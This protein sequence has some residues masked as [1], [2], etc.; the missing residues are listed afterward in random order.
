MAVDLHVVNGVPCSH[1]AGNS[2]TGGVHVDLKILLFLGFLLLLFFGDHGN[3]DNLVSQLG[4]SLRLLELLRELDGQFTGERTEV[5]FGQADNKECTGNNVVDVTVFVTQSAVQRQT[6]EL[7]FLVADQGNRIVVGIDCLNI[8]ANHALQ[9]FQTGIDL[10]NARFLSRLNNHDNDFPVVFQLFAASGETVFVGNVIKT[11]VKHPRPTVSGIAYIAIIGESAAFIH[12]HIA[13]KT[14]KVNVVCE[15]THCFCVVDT[16]FF[17]VVASQILFVRD[18][19]KKVI[20]VQ[21]VGQVDEIV[22]VADFIAASLHNSNKLFLIPFIH[23]INARGKV[24]ELIK[25]LILTE[26]LLNPIDGTLVVGDKPFLVHMAELIL[27]PNPDSFKDLLH[28]FLGC[29]ELYPFTDQLTLVVLA[30]V[31]DKRLETVIHNRH[32]HPPFSHSSCCP[33]RYRARRTQ[34]QTLLRAS[35]RF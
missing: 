17:D 6:F 32:R 8:A 33:A 29:R 9:G 28:L 21:I 34:R 23:L 5:V 12:C 26:Q 35:G 7:A 2:Q 24:V 18:I 16:G 25:A 15:I 13:S 27:R 20:A 1:M 30:E 31:G 3:N 19:G 11:A 4:K 10:F 14:L 22:D